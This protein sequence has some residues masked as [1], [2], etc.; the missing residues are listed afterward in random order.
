MKELIMLA[1]TTGILAFAPKHTL[2]MSDQSDR[3]CAKVKD[4][5]V[6][7]MHDGAVLTGDV[8]LANGVQINADA[9][10]ID[11]DGIKRFLREGEC[12][13]KEGKDINPK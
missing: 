7:M 2:N 3:Y 10:V 9:S 5:K 13:D 6:V 8:K 1:M 11:K 12:V 4:G